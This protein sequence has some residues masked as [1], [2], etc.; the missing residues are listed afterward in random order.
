MKLLLSAL[1]LVSLSYVLAEQ[2]SPIR[3]YVCNELEDK[4]CGDPFKPK[5]VHL[6]QCLN[7]EKYCRKMVQTGKKL[8]YKTMHINSKLILK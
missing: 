8:S 3:C 5:D 6:Q 1:M 4:S 7:G 2:S